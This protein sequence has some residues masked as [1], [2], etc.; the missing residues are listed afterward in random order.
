MRHLVFRPTFK[1]TSQYLKKIGNSSLRRFFSDPTVSQKITLTIPRDQLKSLNNKNFEEAFKD[2]FACLPPEESVLREKYIKEMDVFVG[3][4]TPSPE[5]D[6][7]LDQLR[8]ENN[9]NHKKATSLKSKLTEIR[10]KTSSIQEDMKI[11]IQKLNLEVNQKF[12]TEMIQ[13][14]DVLNNLIIS[15]ED[16]E[17]QNSDDTKKEYE[18][19][20]KG[21]KLMYSSAL[22]ILHRNGVERIDVREGQTF[23]SSNTEEVTGAS[24]G[25]I[26]KVILEGFTYKKR[27]LRKARVEIE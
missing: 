4:A 11:K 12:A 1:C 16:L 18:E 8:E 27:L 26:K 20:L 22:N 5:I 19:F 9:L 23:D 10:E 14:M 2:I 21:L 17:D 25:V 15:V 7:E 24:K 6:K 3:Q 13:V